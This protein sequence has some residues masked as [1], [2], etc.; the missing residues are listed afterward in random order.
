MQK[1]YRIL[2]K[3]DNTFLCRPI[4]LKK[5]EKDFN[6]LDKSDKGN[7]IIIETYKNG[8]SIYI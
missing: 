1:Y 3:S 6:I 4:S 5:A 2:N 7:F 8:S